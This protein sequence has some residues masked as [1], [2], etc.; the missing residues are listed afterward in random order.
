MRDVIGEHVAGENGC[1][2][3][4]AAGR[5][6]DGLR[7]PGPAR[8]ERMPYRKPEEWVRYAE[9]L[10]RDHDGILPSPQS[11]IGRGLWGLYACMRRHSA[12]FAHIKQENMI[13][14]Q[15]PGY[16]NRPA[17]VPPG[18]PAGVGTRIAGTSGSRRGR[19]PSQPAK[20]A[21]S[22]GRGAWV[23]LLVPSWRHGHL[24]R[25]DLPSRV[26]ADGGIEHLV[27]KPP[28]R[29]QAAVV[30]RKTAKLV[31]WFQTLP[32]RQRGRIVGPFNVDV[33]RRC[34]SR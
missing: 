17:S 8:R 29:R 4:P 27:F 18:R 26:L 7:I 15:A 1:V 31:A 5:I 30:L 32:C 10:T 11:L 16:T 20:L 14:G 23:R 3:N 22:H 25:T 24:Y 6:V 2:R 12:L 13:P 33:D 28:H 9:E 21:P 19:R 34:L